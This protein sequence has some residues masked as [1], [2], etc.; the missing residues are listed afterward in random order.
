MHVDSTVF[1]TWVQL[2][3]ANYRLAHA[4]QFGQPLV[5][6]MDYEQYMRHQDCRNLVDQLLMTYSKNRDCLDPFHFVFTSLDRSGKVFPMLRQANLTGQHFMGTM[7]DRSYLD[8]FPRER[9]VY[10]SPHANRTLKEVDANDIYIV[11][12]FIDKA[13]QKPVSLARAKEQG[14]RTAKFPLDTYLL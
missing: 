12:G 2:Q 4:M 5:F 13:C 9:L 8:L 7:T 1:F 6:D 10:L 11:G 3:A 14:I